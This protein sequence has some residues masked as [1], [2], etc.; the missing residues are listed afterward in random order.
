MKPIAEFKRNE[1]RSTTFVE[2]ELQIQETNLKKN[3]NSALGYKKQAG[4][5]FPA[6]IY[7]ISGEE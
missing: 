7:W 3:L 1:V 2:V 5:K 6:P 4:I